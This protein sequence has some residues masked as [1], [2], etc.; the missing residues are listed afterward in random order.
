MQ[1]RLLNEEIASGFPTTSQTECDPVS[2]DEP[3][4]FDLSVASVDSHW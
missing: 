4:S 3:V 2:V 1:A